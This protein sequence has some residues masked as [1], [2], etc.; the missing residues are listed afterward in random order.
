MGLASGCLGNLADPLRGVAAVGAGFFGGGGTPKALIG[1]GVDERSARQILDRSLELGLTLIDTAH[2]YAGGESER[3]IGRW[4]ADDPSRRA[5]VA[6]IDKL[7]AFDRDGEI[8]ID[9]APETVLRCAAESRFR[10]RVDSVDVVMAHGPDPERPARTTLPAFAEL[11]DR[12][13]AR[14]WGVSNVSAAGLEEW[15]DAARDLDLPGPELVEN[16]YNLLGHGDDADVIPLCQR[17]SIG[18][19]A[20]SPLAGGLLT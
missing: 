15:L 6:I 7:G 1:T 5:R 16:Q 12:G 11:I 18:Y 20:F 14:Y 8:V 17:H 10:L 13:Q 19:L 9:L 3:M 4:L 2:S